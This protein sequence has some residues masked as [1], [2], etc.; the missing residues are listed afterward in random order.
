MWTG[1]RPSPGMPQLF[2]RGGDLISFA[3]G[4]P[5]LDLLPLKELSKQF[6]RLTRIGGRIALQYS[7]PHVAGALV[8]A[9]T[10]LMAREGGSTAAANLVPTAGSQMGLLALG[11]GLAAPGETV[12]CQTPAYPGAAAAF[13]TAPS[14]VTW[15]FSTI[16]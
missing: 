6:A 7:T 9:I 10:D 16:R 2:E 3:G 11:L 13:G 1:I 5:D 15:P 4:L 12:L 8:P 14:S